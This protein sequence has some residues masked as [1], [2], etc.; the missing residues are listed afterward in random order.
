MMQGAISQAVQRLDA[1]LQSMRQ[2]DGYGGPVSHWWE[3]NLLYCGPMFDWRYEGIIIGYLNLYRNTGQSI[4]LE[5]ARTAALDV[6]KAQLANGRFRNSSFQIGPI[7]GGTPHEAAIDLALLELAVVLQTNGDE[8]WREIAAIAKH[9]L[10]EFQIKQLW[11]GKAFTDQ[12]GSKTIV[13]NKNATT[14]AALLLY[15]L[16][17]GDSLTEYINGA[18]QAMLAAQVTTS[19]PQQGGIVHVGTGSH[20][21]AIGIYSARTAVSLQ[22]LHA[23]QPEQQYRDQAQQIINFLVKLI[24]PHGTDFG[25]YR[26][27]SRIACPRWISPSGDVLQA[28]LAWQPY[29]DV[30]QEAIDQLVRLLIE[31]QYRTGGIPTAIGLGK[32]GRKRPYRGL[33]D[34]RDIL[35]VAGW[36]DK[37]WRGLTQLVDTPIEPLD[38]TVLRA[39]NV[40]CLWKGQICTFVEDSHH[41]SLQRG[42]K[43]IFSLE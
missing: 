14:L 33:P 5:R 16:L 17:N 27:G 1:W 11:N 25:Y 20:Q 38:P 30:P 41:M 37:A 29:V 18:A 3:S 26:D 4:W 36:I 28:L 39:T 13:P 22:R 12:P 9:N 32:K 21:L 35:P 24:G 23:R 10:T 15:E 42:S 2:P 31:Q 43:T 7:A 8:C 40:S 19:S 34:F 6:R